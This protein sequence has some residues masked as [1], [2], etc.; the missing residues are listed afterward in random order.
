[1][2][3]SNN[4]QTPATGQ[5]GSGTGNPTQ[6]KLY[7]GKYKT[8]EDAVEQGY[9]G[10][11]KGFSELNEKVANLTRLLEVAV[12]PQDPVPTTGPANYSQQYDYG[13]NPQAPV[14]GGNNAAV[15]F[16]MNPQAHLEARDQKLLGQ[17][18]NIVSNTVQ[19]A[20]AVADFKARNPDLVKHE[21]LVRTFMGQ[22]DARKPVS[23]RLEDAAKATRAY[24]SQNFQAPSNPAPAGNDYVEPP[25]GALNRVP[26]GTPPA[27]PS[28]TTED[29]KALVEYLNQRN[30]TKAQNMGI[31]Y[32]PE[33]K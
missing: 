18:A 3:E 12:T 13:R 16:I 4:P 11:E 6:P 28:N 26:P 27:P 2:A 8:L 10:L 23:E 5:P 19:N 15:D 17:V 24:I 1:M 29:E 31:G 33:N 14:P 25:N 21:P 9:G 20:M 30:A 32:D 22:T 7:A